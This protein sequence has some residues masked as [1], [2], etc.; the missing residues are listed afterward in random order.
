MKLLYFTLEDSRS[1]LF[2]NQVIDLLLRRKERFPID[3]ITLLV[4][5][6]PSLIFNKKQVLKAIDKDINLIYIPLSPPMR[7]YT[8]SIMMN[9]IYLY[10]IK[11]LVRISIDY[12]KF[13]VIHCRHYLPS[14]VMK[15]LGAE[16]IH[17]DARSLSLYEYIAAGKIKEDSCVSEYWRTQEKE[18]VE[19]V[20]GMSVVSKSMINYF[21]PHRK[22]IIH[23]CPI[24]VNFDK[25][26]FSPKDRN[27]LRYRLNWINRNIYVYSGSFGLYGVNK[28]ALSKL[29]RYIQSV[30]DKSSFLFLLSN[31][32][33]EFQNFLRS[34]QLSDIDS[35]YFSV[36]PE[37]MSAFLSSADI[38]IHALPPQLDSNTRLGTKIVEY[39]AMGLP[40]VITATVGEAAEL[41]RKFMLGTVI[42]FNESGP[43]SLPR[44]LTDYERNRISLW[45]RENFSI[46]YVLD[47]YNKSYE[48]IIKS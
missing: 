21:N 23:Y 18:L 44:A 5:N 30:D 25:F 15:E 39:W 43:N 19:Y 4:I 22:S 16:N 46:G 11:Q 10:F 7:Y 42:D 28:A 38:G 1:S 3:E 36:Q 12:K 27:V 24:V 9:K 41:S 17:F 48:N 47:E 2:K 35:R 32:E 45:A 8:S 37:N 33:N 26:K 31:G 29:I 20:A 14:L 6:K 13:D 34:F 40:T